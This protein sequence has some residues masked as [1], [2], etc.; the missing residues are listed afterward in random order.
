MELE[1]QMVLF[2]RSVDSGSFS[3]A[4]REL[5]HSPSS[6]S[7]QISNL[8]DKLGVRL[9]TRTVRGISLTDEGRVFYARCTEIRR[10]IASALDLAETLSEKPEGRLRV[11][12]TVAFGKSQILPALPEFFKLHPKITISLDFNDR[13]IDLIEQPIDVAIQFAEQIEDQSLIG[14]KLAVN[15][16]LICAAPSYI[17]RTEPITSPRDLPHHNILRL[18]TVTRWNDWVA[19]LCGDAYQAKANSNFEANS[20]DALY[21]AALAGLGIARLPTYL[22]ADDIAE[23]R[24][25]NLL[26]DFE[27][28]SSN[29]YAVYLMRRNMS[30]KVRVFLDFLSAKFGVAAP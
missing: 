9:L 23:G 10:N 5:N 7:K 28:T 21:H 19:D 8:E 27:D 15:R 14:R 30:P 18:S 16:R 20:A 25:I 3:A 1:S 2:A 26:P 6:V 22:I 24:L 29:I 11:N 17:E 12:T 4:S 13:P